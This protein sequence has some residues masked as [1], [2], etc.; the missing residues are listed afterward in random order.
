M[1]AIKGA[2]AGHPV[3][4]DS[5]IL[6]IGEWRVDPDL[7]EL[8]REGQTIRLEP[9]PMRLLLYLAAHA[10]RV[11]D[12]QQLLDEVWPNVIVTHGSVYQ[13]IA[14]LRR[15]LGD[16]SEH[17]KYIENLPRRGYRLIAPV[18]PWDVHCAAATDSNPAPHGF[19]Q[20]ANG[21]VPVERQLGSG[22]PE[23]AAT[24][25]I[26]D[27]TT[28]Q[29][30]RNSSRWSKPAFAAIAVVLA[31]TL[32]YLALDRFWISRQSPNAS[33]GAPA[34]ERA[35]SSTS[36]TLK[37]VDTAFNPSR[38]SI[39]VLPFVNMSGD[40]SQEYLSDGISEELL[41]ALSRVPE[42]QVA[43]RTSS[44]YFKG[45]HADLATIAHK[46]NV[47][48][49]LEGS[50]RR[51]GHTIR[52]T[53]QLNNAITGFHL[54][55]E[56]YDRDL[57]D[58]L[59]LQTEIAN[60]VASALKVTLL[61]DFGAKVEVGGTRNPAAFDAYLRAAVSHRVGNAKDLE[62][63]IAG[64]TEAIRLDP[65]YAMAYADRSYAFIDFAEDYAKGSSVRDYLDKA[66]ADGRRA[67]AIASNLGRG[68]LAL[69][70]AAERI[71]DFTTASEEYGRALAL[72]P[73][74]AEVLTQYGRFA[75]LMG[76]TE[77]GLAALHHAVV[78]DPLHFGHHDLLGQGLLAARRYNDAISAF[79]SG[80]AVDPSNLWS[81]QW[82]GLAY[83]SIGDFQS[84]RTTCE[85][86]GDEYLRP[87]C[88]A[89]VYHKLGRHADAESM[90][91]TLR[92][93]WG[94]TQ[95]ADTAMIYAQ[96][97]DTAQA[98]NWLETAMRDR[99]ID[100]EQ[101]KTSPWLDPLRKEPRFQAIE[102]A[103]KFP[104]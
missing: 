86:R 99:G 76:Q 71:L 54:W 19:P 39:A 87:F 94:E 84:A 59:K 21:S 40:A 60:A 57:S 46:L 35:T 31:T 74:D 56:T 89:L 101:V 51:S 34:N 100:L 75:V 49:V 64:Y 78:L 85:S 18:A 82:L 42:L 83:Y 7:D 80:K 50:V 62:A 67:V 8:S 73:G 9:R 24:P 25:V 3:P 38:H 61:G 88:L 66:Q 95:A 65:D 28:G 98:L 72:A 36:V 79:A 32:A 37:A 81:S 53:A 12:V 58:V 17:P 96:W 10:G 29:T 13:A 16:E 48:T 20:V 55:S 14:Q 97:G 4:D 47:A 1:L 52:V 68:H 2:Q 6:R 77:S 45:E 33:R 11:V 63:A 102:R 92:A 70:L 90:L 43:A 23:A 41:N 104:D 26:A 69:A 5:R 91:A 93:T 27:S 103:L 44:F 22:A 30:P 15:I